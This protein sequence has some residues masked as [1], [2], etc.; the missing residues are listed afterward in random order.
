MSRF[1]TP[2]RAALAAVTAV[3]L[4]SGCF[5]AI[6]GPGPVATPQPEPDFGAIGGE[7]PVPIETG[8]PVEPV[9]SGTSDFAPVLDDLG[10]LTVTVPADWRE[11]DGE[12]FTTANG[13]QWASIVVAPDVEGFLES[14]SVPGLEI[15]ATA[16]EGPT[17]D[18]L[19][20]LLRSVTSVYAACATVLHTQVPY[21]DP[22]FTGYESAYEDCGP[23][24]TVAFAIT[25]MN[26]S[27]TQALFVR[28]QVTRDY[29]A[30]EVYRRVVESFDT[31]VRGGATRR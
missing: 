31:T 1:T 25:A 5:P 21:E 16:I 7:S 4:L 26:T 30:N 24:G 19:L 17:N 8:T 18:Q 22:Y 14:W 27:G 15:A 13:Q 9:E 28:A 29:D 12:P 23:D 20:G 11:V 10:V 6:L 3:A 2:V